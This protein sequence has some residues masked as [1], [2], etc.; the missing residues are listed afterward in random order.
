ML[1]KEIKESEFKLSELD[2]SLLNT[3]KNLEETTAERD[4]LRVIS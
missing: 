2:N 1:E 4:S 3:N